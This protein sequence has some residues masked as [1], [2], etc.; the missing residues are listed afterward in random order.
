[1][2]NWLSNLIEGLI[3]LI[4]GLILISY[5]FLNIEPIISFYNGSQVSAQLNPTFAVL[6]IIGFFLV[7][8]GTA[9]SSVTI[10]IHKLNKKYLELKS[11]LH[12]AHTH[13]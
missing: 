1:L 4:V 3:F 6:V 7:G 5:N 10:T 13:Q 12:N 11:S 8:V 9:Q 2:E